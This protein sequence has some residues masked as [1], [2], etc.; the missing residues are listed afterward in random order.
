MDNMARKE[1]IKTKNWPKERKY[2]V[3]VCVCVC[4]YI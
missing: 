4:V 3:C 2:N 1:K